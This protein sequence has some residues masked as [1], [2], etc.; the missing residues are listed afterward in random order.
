MLGRYVYTYLKSQGYEVRGHSREINDVT[1]YREPQIK[2][3]LYYGHELRPGDVV[4]NCIGVIKPQ[5]EKTGKLRS[6]ATNSTF[7]HHLANVCEEESLRLIHV[8]TDCVFSGKIGLYNEDDIHDCEDV[9]G[10]TKSLGE[11]EKCTVIRTSIIG[12]EIGTGRSLIEWVKTRKN[13]TA[14]G[15]TNHKWNGVT[16]LQLAK[17]FEDI[18]VNNK[19]W[20]GVTHIFSPDTLTK[21]ELVRTISDI[22]ELN[23]QITPTI[24]VNNMDRT[25]TTVRD[26]YTFNIPSI[27][28][29]IQEQKDFYE[30]LNNLL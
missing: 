6:I 12:E 29:Q 1:F 5:I 18:I 4:I 13:D 17:I 16:C 2:A 24:D 28:Q 10:K 26:E 7:P 25:L 19:Y 11:P 30:N 21:E 8:S 14:L 27:T 15:F 3:L 9:Y 23:V 20:E 22:Y